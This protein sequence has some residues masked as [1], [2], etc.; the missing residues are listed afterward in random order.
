M[1]WK[2]I[3]SDI[4]LFITQ[5]PGYEQAHFLQEEKILLAQIANEISIV[6]ERKRNKQRE[7]EIQRNLSRTD[8]LTILGEITAG[9][10]H[11]LNTPLGNILG[12]AEL[13]QQ[14]T[15]D[16]QVAQDAQKIIN[17]A[18]FAREVVKKLM[19]FS[20]EMPQ[21]MQVVDVKPLVENALKLW[22]PNFQKAELEIQ[23]VCLK[24]QVY[25]Q[26]DG[27][28]LTQVLFNLLSNAIYASKPKGVVTVT[29][30]EEKNDLVLMIAD[31]GTG[32]PEA[33]RN[34]IFEP[35]FTTKP[36]GEGSG[37]GLSV[38]HGIIKSHRGK[39]TC[40]A[41]YPKGTIFTLTLPLKQ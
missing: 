35:F 3:Q 5:L 29:L 1:C 2:D 34:Q 30:A 23:F 13:I 41:N 28:Q 11:E 19:F 10:A 20:C 4:L 32:I 8:R 37:L 24:E 21:H 40:G 31:E 14:K 17:S 25:A 12:F 27:I 18:I 16:G 22:G 36:V 33:I 15:N 26:L 38:A 6:I 9:I 7:T 39:L